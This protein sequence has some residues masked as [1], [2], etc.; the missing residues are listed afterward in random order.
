MS[1]RNPFTDFANQVKD[2]T[3]GRGVQLLGVVVAVVGGLL[4]FSVVRYNPESN[5]PL[6]WL[7]IMAGWT[8]PLLAAAVL[9]IGLVL[10]F[11]D[12]A[13]Y[14]SAEA[15]VGVELLLLGL[16]VGYVRRQQ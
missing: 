13:G 14:W 9:A 15:L 5:A 8:A 11:G 16:Q 3:A 1:R 10:V 6:P 12:R 2:A 7:T 4:L